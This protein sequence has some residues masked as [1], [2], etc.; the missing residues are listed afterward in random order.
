MVCQLGMSERIGPVTYRQGETHPFLGRELAEPRDFSE[1]TGR[2]IDEEIQKLVRDMEEKATSIL[3]E[4]KEELGIL[5]GAL[6]E[7]ETLTGKE[8]DELL[9]AGA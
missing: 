6:Q 7:R 1:Y 2:L 9:G 8:V 4:A 3:R 5:A